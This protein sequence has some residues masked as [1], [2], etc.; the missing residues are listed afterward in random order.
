MVFK[1]FHI[2]GSFTGSAVYLVTRTSQQSKLDSEVKLSLQ[3][4]PPSP[5]NTRKACKQRL[6]AATVE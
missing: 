6:T 4:T 1:F 2:S 5:G 3:S